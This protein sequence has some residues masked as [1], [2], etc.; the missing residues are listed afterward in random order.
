MNFAETTLFLMTAGGNASL[1]RK[2]LNNDYIR[3]NNNYH[4]DV[5]SAR[6]YIVNYK[7]AV[8]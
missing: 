7:S 2:E 1:V 6:A 8:P 3:G 4:M 5:T